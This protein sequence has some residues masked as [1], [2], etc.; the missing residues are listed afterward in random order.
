MIFFCHHMNDVQGNCLA[1]CPIDGLSDV[2]SIVRLEGTASFGLSSFHQAV[3][4][5]LTNSLEAG[6]KEIHV[7]IDVP[8][9]SLKVGDDG[10]G[11]S[12]NDLSL[13]GSR[14]ATSKSKH[15]IVSSGSRG[16][17]IA[18][19]C[20]VAVVEISSRARV[21][22][23]VF[24]FLLCDQQSILYRTDT[25]LKP[26]VP[27]SEDL[28]SL[29]DSFSTQGCYETHSCLLR[30]GTLLH[31]KLAPVQMM[32]HGTTVSIRN[33]CFNRPVVQ[34]AMNTTAG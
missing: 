11:M 15:E 13:L 26:T 10:T 32:R 28:H 22:P 19:I 5:C 12:R 29:N 18:A 24:C 1:M 34:R 27:A 6:S 3:E 17:G 31:L 21:C 33:V 7:D 2:S 30:D 9:C 8:G 4:I 25:Q 20:S 23:L 16:D 14:N